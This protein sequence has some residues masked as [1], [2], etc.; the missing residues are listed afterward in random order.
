M[1]LAVAIIGV[2]LVRSS[3]AALPANEVANDANL[4]QSLMQL[5]APNSAA[6]VRDNSCAMLAAYVQM[7]KPD[8]ELQA[9][10]DSCGLNA[11]VDMCEAT[12]Y[13]VQGAGRN[14]NKLKCQKSPR[15]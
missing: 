2:C 13:I 4:P 9:F 10:Y 11:D 7:R 3:F 8:S 6:S 14:P 15:G 5:Q 1:R 12:R